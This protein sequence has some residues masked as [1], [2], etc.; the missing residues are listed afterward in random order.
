[1]TTLQDVAKAAGVSSS[2]VS[3]VLKGNAKISMATTK[4]V[5][6]A[7]RRLEYRP[8]ILADKFTEAPTKVLGVVMAMQIQDAFYFPILERIFNT[9][10]Q[11][12]YGVLSYRLD[13]R[14]GTQS[15]SDI[16]KA[17]E[18]RVD[19]IIF[20]GVFSFNKDDL[21]PFIQQKC[22]MVSLFGVIDAPGIINCTTDN[23]QAAYDATQYLI[24][25]GHTRIAHMLIHKTFEHAL[26]R[27]EGYKA[28]LEEHGIAYNPDLVAIGDFSYEGAYKAALQLIESQSFTAVFCF[29]DVMADA[30]IRAARDRGLKVPEDVSVMGFDD[31]VYENPIFY[32]APLMTTMRQPRREMADFAI[33]AIMDSKRGLETFE[34]TVF[35]PML[36]ERNTT[37]PIS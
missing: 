1:M 31:I 34:N 7:A 30:F 12:G 23:V 24:R 15:N 21:K 33:K 3:R 5:L 20:V 36:I 11:L 29:N 37:K 35:R 2:T 4:K 26:E 22:P 27:L 17:M 19:A 18:G 6:D 14:Y 8:I 9:A 10:D 13:T 16:L 25:L 32:P 28:A